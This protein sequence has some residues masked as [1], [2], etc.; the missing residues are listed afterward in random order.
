MRIYMDGEKPYLQ[1]WRSFDVEGRER[2]INTD[3]D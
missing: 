3:G 1:T 2:E